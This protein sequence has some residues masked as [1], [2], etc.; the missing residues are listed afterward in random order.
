[1]RE[2]GNRGVD[3]WRKRGVGEESQGG[4]K[5]E[6]NINGGWAE[7]E[8]W[9]MQ[10]CRRGRRCAGEKRKRRRSAEEWE[11]TRMKKEESREREKLLSQ[12]TK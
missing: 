10:N 4:E 3:K 11:L 9:E 12:G 2:Q 1:M 7:E 5:Q 8:R 6:G